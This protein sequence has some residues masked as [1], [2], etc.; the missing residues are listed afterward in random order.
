[1]TTVNKLVKTI[2]KTGRGN[3]NSFIF[4][5]GNT[6]EIKANNYLQALKT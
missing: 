6:Y 4:K 3:L 1:M 5:L 2:I